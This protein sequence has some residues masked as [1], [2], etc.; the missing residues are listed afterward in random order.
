M[1]EYVCVREDE[2]EGGE[3]G[4]ANESDE[5]SRMCKV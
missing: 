3:P 4:A 2:T 1:D 5:L